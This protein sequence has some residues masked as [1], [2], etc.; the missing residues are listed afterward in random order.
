MT[1]RESRLPLAI[2][3]QGRGPIIVLNT[4]C[5]DVGSIV[6]MTTHLYDVVATN[7][8][9]VAATCRLMPYTCDQLAAGFELTPTEFCVDVDSYQTVALQVTAPRLLLG[10]FQH[11]FYFTVDNSLQS[12]QLTVKGTVVSPS[13][14]LSVNQLDFGPVGYGRYHLRIDRGAAGAS[15]LDSSFAI[16]VLSWRHDH[17]QL[18]SVAHSD[19]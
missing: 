17:P 14:Q 9:L 1:G 11:V 7:K 19:P 10:P 3:G 2:H 15:E 13:F 12:L 16:I 8:G 18:C 4:D 5:L 6:T